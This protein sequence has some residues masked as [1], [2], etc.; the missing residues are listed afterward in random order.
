MDFSVLS[1]LCLVF[2]QLP[3]D[4]VKF[5][6]SVYQDLFPSSSYQGRDLATLPLPQQTRLDEANPTSESRLLP[7]VDL[8]VKQC[9]R[10]FLKEGAPIP[11]KL[12]IFGF[13]LWTHLVLLI[14]VAQCTAILAL[15]NS[16]KH[17][18]IQVKGLN[19]VT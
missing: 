5:I 14:R 11:G 3:C 18:V 17:V 13:I 15:P 8:A 9:L 2:C 19:L 10:S 1:P 12:F 6:A 7:L 4:L 16:I